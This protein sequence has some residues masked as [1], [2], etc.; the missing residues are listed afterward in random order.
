MV[1]IFFRWTARR[2]LLAF[3]LCFLPTAFAAE[4]EVVAVGTMFNFGDPGYMEIRLDDGTEVVGHFYYKYIEFNDISEWDEDKGE[5]LEIGIAESI[6]PSIRRI[7]TGIV[8]KLDFDLPFDPIEVLERA[9][10]SEPGGSTTIGMLQCSDGSNRYRRLE[11]EYTS[12]ELSR[13]GGEQTARKLK[14]LEADFS[15]YV[16]SLQSVREGLGYF[17]SREVYESQYNYAALQQSHLLNIRY[18]YAGAEC[19]QDM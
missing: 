11:I 5:A 13:C 4:F 2:L 14:K 8:Y 12:S 17:G 16:K 19:D 18:L 1:Q 10:L 3:G 6:G 15:A 9:C 7:S